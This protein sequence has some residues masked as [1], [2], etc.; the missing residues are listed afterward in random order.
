[1]TNKKGL[2]VVLVI[3]LGLFLGACGN[4]NDGDKANDAKEE[5]NK[6]GLK[7]GEIKTLTYDELIEKLDNEES[8]FLLP[9]E[10]KEDVFEESGVKGYFSESLKEHGFGA[11]Y[12]YLTREED[13]EELREYTH[14]KYS[15]MK[16]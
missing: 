11:Y 6:N 9:L 5:T 10:V 4:S 3:M 15:W 1:M 13:D 16:G 14:R 7:P 8:F 12:V 2:F